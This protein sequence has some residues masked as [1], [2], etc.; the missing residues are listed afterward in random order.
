MRAQIVC[1]VGKL[2]PLA[3]ARGCTVAQLALAWL[4]AQARSSS[5]APSGMLKRYRV[6]TGWKPAAIAV[7]LRR[8]AVPW[9]AS[10]YCV[11]KSSSAN[12]A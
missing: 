6:T 8:E 7:H 9:Q 12:I 2:K 4:H 11:A 10:V 3:E 1:R 5:S